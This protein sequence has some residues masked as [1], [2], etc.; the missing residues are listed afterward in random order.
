MNKNGGKNCVLGESNNFGLISNCNSVDSLK[1]GLSFLTK[2]S[3]I[4]CVM[5]GDI[6]QQVVSQ[7]ISI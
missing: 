1:D 5:Y 3:A 2:K 6:I 4:N 7:K